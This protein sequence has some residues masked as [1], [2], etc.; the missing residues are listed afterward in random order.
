MFGTPLRNHLKFC[1]DNSIYINNREVLNYFYSDKISSYTKGYCIKYLIKSSNTKYFKILI[2]SINDFDEEL[3]NQLIYIIR[4]DGN[5]QIALYL[6]KQINKDTNEKIKMFIY[7][8]LI[9]YNVRYGLKKYYDWVKKNNKTYNEKINGALKYSCNVMLS[10]I[11]IKILVLT[12]SDSFKDNEFN[13]LYSSVNS[14]I[15][16]VSKKNKILRKVLM[17]IIKLLI[18]KNREHK[19][20]GLLH[21]TIESINEENYTNNEISLEEIKKL[22]HKSKIL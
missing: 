21:Y 4:E 18:L 9:K 22:I 13:S 14:A 5:K 8:Q 3:V 6:L 7:E 19:K 20:I 12:M 10:F 17:F 16:N 2:S 1:I 15:I 11:Y